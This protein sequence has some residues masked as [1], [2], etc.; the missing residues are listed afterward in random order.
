MRATHYDS[1]VPTETADTLLTR[2]FERWRI[3]GEDGAILRGDAE[4]EDERMIR[5]EH[6]LA[7]HTAL[8][9]LFPQ[10]RELAYRWMTTRNAAFEHRTPVE[11][12]R[13]T[14]LDGLVA[15]RRYL[16]RSLGS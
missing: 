10:N 15:V 12:V 9:T 3:S 13:Q 8:R 14:G 4:A 2:L 16:E 1:H 5:A 6:L 7:I 11:V